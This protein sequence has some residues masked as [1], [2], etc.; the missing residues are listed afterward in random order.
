[1]SP[2]PALPIPFAPRWR[3]LSL[4]L[5]A[6][7]LPAHAVDQPSSYPGCA[8]RQVSVAPGGTV[9]VDLSRCHAFGLGE[10]A[11]PPEHG[12]ATPGD[13]DPVD[14]YVYT[15]TGAPGAASDR[16]VVLDD[17]SDYIVVNVALGGTASPL[18]AIPATLP[19]MYAGL[20][21]HQRL[22]A[23]GGTAPYRYQ[24][25]TGALPAGLALADGLITGTPTQR[26]PYSFS[27]RVQDA[28][29]A[30]AL[31]SYSAAV[32][33]APLSV[34][35]RGLTAVQGAPFRQPLQARGGVAPHQFALEPGAS[36]PP[37]LSLSPAGVL[38]GTPEGSPARYTVRVRVTDASGGSGR[39]F[40][41]EALSLSVVPQVDGQPRLSIALAPV[42]VA[43]DEGAALVYTVTRSRV[44]PE[45]TVVTLSV[46]G[47]ARLQG[48]GRVRIP[49][50]QA[51]ATFRVTPLA[52]DRPEADETVVLGIAPGEGYQVGSPSSAQGILVDDDLP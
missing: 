35:P 11:T 51:S 26:G 7:A 49:A 37:G 13:G 41:V 23:E 36:L 25:A 19:A 40:E 46:G 24:L 48:L 21:F 47:S 38:E 45:P 16:F 10:V 6:L 28:A 39:H 1:M 4:A 32:L 17:N 34:T 14:S 22:Q 18:V 30:S 33:P 43:E 20:A 12:T 3:A 5:L 31:R 8:S 42:A 52:D 15:H 2:S 50:G 27:L 29:G 9:R 44:L